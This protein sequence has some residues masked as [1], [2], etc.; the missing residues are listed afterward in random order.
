MAASRFAGM[1]APPYYAVIFSSQRRPGDDAAYGAAAERM[2]ALAA[3]QPGYLGVEHAR[4][5]DGF[6]ITVSYWASE[7]AIRAWKRNAEHAEARARGRSEWY[8]GYE[9]RVAK[10][11]RAYALG[12]AGGA[13]TAAGR[14][15]PPAAQPLP[16]DATV[17]T[18]AGTP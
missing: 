7:E 15:D 5:P 3:E 18:A 2:L 10:V 6:G 13:G 17:A 4:D 1:P 8:S 11:E 14:A 16:A 9:L 12:A